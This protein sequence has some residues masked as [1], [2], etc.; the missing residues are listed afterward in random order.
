MYSKNF[1]TSFSQVDIFIP[2]SAT[3]K[4]FRT[5]IPTI[6]DLSKLRHS[7]QKSE[8]DLIS[9]KAFFTEVCY[10]KKN[11]VVSIDSIQV[12]M[13][14]NVYLINVSVSLDKNKKNL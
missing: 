6:S 9:F 4:F 11:C 10:F 5:P 7:P 1:Y 3:F 13:I 14:K 2:Q 12:L 8:N